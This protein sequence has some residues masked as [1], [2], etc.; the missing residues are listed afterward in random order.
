[1][2]YIGEQ[3]VEERGA[4]EPDSQKLQDQEPDDQEQDAQDPDTHEQDT[5]GQD[6]QEQDT[7]EQDDQELDDQERSAEKGPCRDSQELRAQEPDAQAKEPSC[8][9]CE[10]R[11]ARERLAREMRARQR[12]AQEQ[13]GRAWLA[14]VQDTQAGRQ[15]FRESQERLTQAQA[16]GMRLTQGL[17]RHV[18]G[19]QDRQAGQEERDDQGEKQPSQVSQE[20]WFPGGPG[21]Q[22]RYVQKWQVACRVN[23]A[24]HYLKMLRAKTV[25]GCPTAGPG[26]A[27]QRGQDAQQREPD[28]QLREEDALNRD[29]DPLN[30]EQAAHIR[31]QGDQNREQ[32]DAKD[33]DTEVRGAGKRPCS[34]PDPKSDQ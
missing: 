1:M 3:G 20:C 32:D 4:E 16:E 24:K 17:H 22:L 7:Q 14:S 5:Q 28:A 18:L 31:G 30:R 19:P 26:R 9:G 29:L 21:A 6:T 12:N 2:P 33:R 27:Q 34:H 11:D 23:A 8:W 10:F 15:A 13:S 25:A